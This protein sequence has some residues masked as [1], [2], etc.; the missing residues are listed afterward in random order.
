ML[1]NQ[2]KICS[3]CESDN[4]NFVK[5]R[6]KNGTINIRQQC[7]DCGFLHITNFK[8]IHFNLDKLNFVNLELKNSLKEKYLKIKKIK[9]VMSQYREQHTQRKWDYYFNKYLKSDEWKHKRKLIMD[10]YN[11]TCQRCSNKATD[12]HHKTYENIFQE[13]FED[14]EPLCRRCHNKEHNLNKMQ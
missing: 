3:N 9:T 11:W 4:L 12:L 10:F 13:K 1:V 14:L 7:F 6:F 5:Y 2:K 8:K